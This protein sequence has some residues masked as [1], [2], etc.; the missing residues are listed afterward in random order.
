VLQNTNSKENKLRRFMMYIV[1]SD[2]AQ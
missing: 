2:K 1:I